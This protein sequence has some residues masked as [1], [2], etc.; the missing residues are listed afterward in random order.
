MGRKRAP[1]MPSLA[2]E[3]AQLKE[4]RA[5]TRYGVFPWTANGC[6]P[7][8]QALKVYKVKSAAQKHA[9]KLNEDGAWTQGGYVVRSFSLPK[10]VSSENERNSTVA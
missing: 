9:D 3:K 2:D 6:Y 4:E 7:A 10:E 1:W 5:N 8:S